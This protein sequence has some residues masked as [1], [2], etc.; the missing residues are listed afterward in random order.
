MQYVS[1]IYYPVVS[2]YFMVTFVTIM[3]TSHPHP[4]N[5]I[6]EALFFKMNLDLRSFNDSIGATALLSKTT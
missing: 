2:S 3:C 5:H 1:K 4:D 6:P